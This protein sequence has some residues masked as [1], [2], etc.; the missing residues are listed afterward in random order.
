MVIEERPEREMTH[1]N[2]RRIAAKDIDCWNPAFD[3]TPA[4]LITG[5]ITDIGVFKPENLK[6]AL[7]EHEPVCPRLDIHE[8]TCL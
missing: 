2:G 8:W 7:E 1:I 6:A 3:I 4:S 5:I